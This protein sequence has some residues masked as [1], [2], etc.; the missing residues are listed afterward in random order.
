MEPLQENGFESLSGVGLSDA[1]LTS[2]NTASE[3]VA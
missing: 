1:A 2:A 3:S